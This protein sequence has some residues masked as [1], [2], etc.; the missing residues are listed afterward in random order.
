MHPTDVDE[1]PRIWLRPSQ[2]KVKHTSW[3]DPTLRTI[4]L[5]RSSSVKTQCRLPVETIINLAEN[6]VPPK[7]FIKLVEDALVNL[8]TPLITWDG[9]DAM[10]I[11]WC[12]VAR[13]G[14]V[15]SSR[16]A[17]K[18]TVLARVKGY[19]E[20][21][22]GELEYDG[23]E[24]EAQGPPTSTAWWIDEVSGC[25]SSLEETV[26]YLLDAGFTPQSCGVLNS[27]LEKIVNGCVDRYI[28]SYRI[29]LPVGKS[30]MAFIVPDEFGVL[31]AGEFFL[32]SSHYD[33]QTPD[34][35]P[36]DIL[37]GDALI[38]RHPCKVS[39]VV[40]TDWNVR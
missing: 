23:E 4:D 15:M 36:T 38:T 31:E 17:R 11:L 12:A 18:E 21:E 13:V 8:V 24:E 33:L 28:E 34:G 7:A 25:P 40:W 10:M 26:M 19:S 37:L 30:A 14:G 2:I 6:G 1:R 3:E 16:L 22:S 29:D 20:R 27:K 32:K 35:L 5:L 9:P 39:L